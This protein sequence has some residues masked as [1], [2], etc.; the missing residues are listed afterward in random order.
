MAIKHTHLKCILCG[1][2]LRNDRTKCPCGTEELYVFDPVLGC[3]T[4]VVAREKMGDGIE[5]EEVKGRGGEVEDNGGEVGK[6][7]ERVGSATR[8]YKARS[9]KTHT[10]GRG[11][12]KSSATGQPR[13]RGRPLRSKNRKKKI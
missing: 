7:R 11:G 4:M 6:A 9:P 12:I 5:R 3:Y 13:K 10:G 2:T 1:A 8:R